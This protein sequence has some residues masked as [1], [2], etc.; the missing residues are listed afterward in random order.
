MYFCDDSTRNLRNGNLNRTEFNQRLVLLIGLQ[1]VCLC[2]VICCWC[3]S[4]D[5]NGRHSWVMANTQA[6]EIYD[7]PKRRQWILR[8][9]WCIGNRYGSIWRIGPPPPSLYL[10]LSRMRTTIASNTKSETR[11]T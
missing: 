4:I 5:R 7:E 3:C 9:S 8:I 6:T 2:L 11:V 10:Y 1:Y